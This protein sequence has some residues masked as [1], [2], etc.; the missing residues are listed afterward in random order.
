MIEITDIGLQRW[1][2]YQRERF[3]VVAHGLL[4][5]IFVCSTMGYTRLSMGL[6]G[7]PQISSLFAAFFGCFGFFLLLRIADEFKDFDDDK[8]YRAY[9]PVPRGLISL[10]ELRN[11]GIVIVILQVSLLIVIEPHLLYFYALTLGYFF[12]MSK[13]FFAHHWL[14]SQPLIYLFSHM[15]IMPLIALFAMS[16]EGLFSQEQS[17]PLSFL[18]ASFFSGVV[19]EIGRKIRAPEMEERGVETYSAVWGRARAVFVWLLAMAL[20]AGSTLYAAM[21]ID[22]LMISAVIVCLLLLLSLLNAGLFLNNNTVKRGKL[23][24]HLSA[25]WLLATYT[26][27]GI[28]PL[29]I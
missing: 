13:E 3:P 27:V 26:G 2:I 15:I 10:T 28:I 6:E 7:W 5:L 8:R 16:H 19:L 25:L 23:F 22:S 12:L 21:Q 4:I 29:L 11:L 17:I 14:K 9:R 24:E 1:W 18:A 20:A